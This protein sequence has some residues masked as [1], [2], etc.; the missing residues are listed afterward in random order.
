MLLPFSVQSQL[1]RAKKIKHLNH[2]AQVSGKRSSRP[3][4]RSSVA[5]ATPSSLIHAPRPGWSCRPGDWKRSNCDLEFWEQLF[6]GECSW[7]AHG[8]HQVSS[9]ISQPKTLPVLLLTLHRTLKKNINNNN[10]NNKDTDEAAEQSFMKA[11]SA[12]GL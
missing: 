9:S 3:I 10:N 8:G 5:T 12:S 6:G 4:S 7:S 2:S 11:V 1:R